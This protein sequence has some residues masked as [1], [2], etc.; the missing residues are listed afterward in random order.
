MKPSA[1]LNYKS[2]DYP[3][4]KLLGVD[5]KMLPRYW[6]RWF[7]NIEGSDMKQTDLQIFY[8]L[9]A[10]LQG[11]KKILVGMSGY[12]AVMALYLPE[13]WLEAFLAQTH[14]QGDAI[15]L[16][17]SWM[18]AE[19]LLKIIQGITKPVYANKERVITRDDVALLHAHFKSFEEEFARECRQLEVF[20]VTKKGIYE[21]RSLIENAEKVFPENL[22]KVMPKQTIDD[23]RQAGRCL[24]FWVLPA[25]PFLFF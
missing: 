5:V 21:S 19:R 22:L 17:D 18:I 14:T 16:R 4:A 8:Q 9:G 23:L 7:S 25:C 2:D 3:P 1:K 15:P 13:Q 10:A 6:G 24:A 12:D 11:I 20:T